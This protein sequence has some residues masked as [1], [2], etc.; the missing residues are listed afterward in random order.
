MSV[1]GFIA[2]MPKAELNVQL[3]GSLTRPTLIT[4]AE[5]NEINTTLKHYQQW[6]TQFDKPDYRRLPDLVK[7]V[8]GWMRFSEELVRVVYDLGVALYKNGARYAEVGV[9]PMLYE[10]IGMSLDEMLLALNDG[11]DRVLRAW[12]VEMN[13]VISIPRDEPRRAEDLARWA[14]GLTAR[15]GNV[16]GI[17][18]VGKEDVQPIAQFERPFRNAEKKDMPRAARAGDV[19]GGEGVAATVRA[20]NPNRLIDAWK[21]ME[22]EDAVAAVREAKATVTLSL[23]RAQKHGWIS[24]IED[25]PLRVMLDAGIPVSLGTDMPTFYHTSLIQEYTLAVEKLG[26]TV[27]ELIQVALNGLRASFQSDEAK[28]EMVQMFS[29]EY[30]RLREEHGV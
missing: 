19:L 18:L 9:N 24:Q 30:T 11:R 5:G 27:D 26:L 7:T 4:I 29:E 21:L 16:L 6:L 25:Y 23:V 15:R 3:E 20:L 8:N 28:A 2:A 13:W 12:N 22:S 10:G 17:A 1:A 14:T